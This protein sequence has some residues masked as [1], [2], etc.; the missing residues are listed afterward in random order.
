MPAD[1]RVEARGRRARARMVAID[2]RLAPS[3]RTRRR[4][5]VRS[6]RRSRR[7]AYVKHAHI[8]GH[9]PVASGSAGRSLSV[10]SLCSQGGTSPSAWPNMQHA[11]LPARK[12]CKDL[13]VRGSWASK[14]PKCRPDA[15]PP[16]SSCSL[17]VVVAML[18]TTVRGGEPRC[19]LRRPRRKARASRARRPTR[20]STRKKARAIAGPRTPI[21]SRRS[22]SS[23]S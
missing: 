14:G 18:A 10:A 21:V 13:K 12:H 20:P 17:S 3:R 2:L 9:K 15:P 7:R 8:H 11:Q 4:G 16:S 22:P 5:S 6:L 19:H 1:I 23:P